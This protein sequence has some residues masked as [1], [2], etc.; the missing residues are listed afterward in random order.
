MP[1][2][3]FQRVQ[4]RHGIACHHDIWCCCLD[5]KTYTSDCCLEDLY[6]FAWGGLMRDYRWA[7]YFNP[8]LVIISC[9]DTA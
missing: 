8:N 3:P 5:V 7:R 6:V 4:S 2:D 9:R 1:S